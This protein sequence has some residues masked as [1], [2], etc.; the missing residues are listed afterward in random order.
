MTSY[1]NIVPGTRVTADLL[2]SMMPVMIYK[3]AHTDRV[4]TTTLADDPDFTVPLEAGGVYFVKFFLW[5]AATNAT[6]FK[7]AWRIPSGATGSRSGIGPD[8]GVV[9]STTS[10]GGQGR[11]GVHNSSTVNTYGSRD[12]PSLTCFAL[13]EGMVFMGS[14]AGTMSLQWAQATSG[15]SLVRLAQGSYMEIRRLA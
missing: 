10:S 4:S 6:R 1:P 15:T 11:W 3:S 14:S 12:D 9:L 7:C 2:N 5:H 8:Q 13:E